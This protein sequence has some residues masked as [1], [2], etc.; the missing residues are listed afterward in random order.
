MRLTL[1]TESSV[2][3]LQHQC[4][5]FPCRVPVPSCKLN[6]QTFVLCTFIH[7]AS[8]VLMPIVKLFAVKLH[9]ARLKD[10][11]LMHYIQ[12]VLSWS[13]N[14][15]KRMTAQEM[16][17]DGHIG[18]WWQSNNFKNKGCKQSDINKSTK[19]ETLKKLKE[20]Y[21]HKSSS[22]GMVANSIENLT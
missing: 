1:C 13:K 9:L 10:P 20:L 3:H 11:I 18:V 21:M 14:Y 8:C 6:S 2:W 12:Q 22:N 17:V 4:Q 16:K 7:C 5:L 15:C 19:R